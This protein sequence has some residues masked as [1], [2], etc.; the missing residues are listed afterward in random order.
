MTLKSGI[1]ND[2]FSQLRISGLT[3]IASPKNNETALSRL[4]DMAEELEGRNICMGYN[5]EEAP[6]PNSQM[7]TAKKFNYMFKTNLA[8]RLAA[9]FGKMIPPSLAAMASQS[10]S[11]VSS[12]VAAENIRQVQPSRRSPLG[13]GNH[14]NTRYRRYQYPDPLPPN[15][16]A[17]N[18]LLVGNTQDYVETFD[19]YL[20][21]ETIDSFEITADAGIAIVSSSN[22]DTAVSYRINAIDNSTQGI[23]Q[24]VKI[25]VMT[26][27]ARI[28]TRLI[29][30][31][32]SSSTTVGAA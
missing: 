20:G 13:S 17:T 18:K 4:E 31:E 29:N 16:C 22:T 19:T 14:R 21:N 7:G 2:A 5:F 25:T 15:Q 6:D 12:M 9:D 3:V 1:I 11:S 8:L 26:N 28:E 30:F 10:M 24:Q 27:T 32:V 23:W